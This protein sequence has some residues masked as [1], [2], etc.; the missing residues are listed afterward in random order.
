MHSDIIPP[1]KNSI[2]QITRD[3]LYE[4]E[5]TEKVFFTERPPREKRFPRFVLFLL[6]GL[7]L[8]GGIIYAKF[9]ERTVIT[10]KPQTTTLDIREN[11]P[12]HLADSRTKQEDD[13]L[14]Y[15]MIYISSK[16]TVRNPFLPL[17]AANVT[18][19]ATTAKTPLTS[20]ELVATSTGAKLSVYIV[21]ATGESLP[22]RATTR[23]D[24]NGVIYSITNSITVPITKDVT[25][26]KDA[27]KYYLP[28]FQGTAQAQS[29]YAVAV[30]SL[31]APADTTEGGSTSTVSE[32]SKSTVPEDIL[33]LLPDT[34]VALRK[35]TVY[36]L[37]LGQTAVV[38]FD[39][40][41]LL[42]MLEKRSPA[43]QEYVTAFKPMADIVS[44]KVQI[45]DYEL[46]SSTETGRPIAFKKLILEIVPILDEQ[47]TKTVFINF[48]T[49]SMD[50]IAAQIANYATLDVS[51]T[52]FWKQ[53]VA[54]E[55]RVDVKIEE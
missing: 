21:N 20:T 22:L 38:I 1:K 12:L 39:K 9:S 30:S 3:T 4:E 34:S 31:A 50:K 23:F 10:F 26:F 32:V 15:S 29:I 48:S 24:V 19:S 52:P 47:K 14:A 54:G 11:I 2:R 49:E 45:A 7:T 43:F 18:T 42:A 27:P 41:D 8:I 28:G 36:D 13:S 33:S 37:L 35:N 46:E 25:P 55:S 44:Y 40:R 16:D 17:P 5:V 51:N 53:N 6:I